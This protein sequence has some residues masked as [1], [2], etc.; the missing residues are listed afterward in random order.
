M[1]SHALEFFARLSDS[2]G[3]SGFER[4]PSTLVKGYVEPYADEIGTDRL[5][6]LHFTARGSSAK[7]VIL[8]P[9]HVDEVGFIVSGV[10]PQGFLTFNAIGGWFDQVLLGQKVKV[11]TNRLGRPLAP[12]KPLALTGSWAGAS[13]LNSTGSIICPSI[14]SPS[15]IVGI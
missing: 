10:N 13:C 5:G 3:P 6:S 9:G 4:E 1:E 11:R 2:F 12:L 15:I 7:P 8:L 14:P